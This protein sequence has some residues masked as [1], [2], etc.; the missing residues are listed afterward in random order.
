MSAPLL[1]NI[2]IIFLP[3][4]KYTTD[5]K[6]LQPFHREIGHFQQK[7]ARRN[8]GGFQERSLTKA[9]LPHP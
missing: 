2:L 8:P 5:K 4:E 1:R 3:T 6:E 9:S 7:T